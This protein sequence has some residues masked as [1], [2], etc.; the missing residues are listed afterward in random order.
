MKNAV[1]ISYLDECFRL[2]PESGILT[3]KCRPRHHF[4]DNRSHATTN[5]MRAGKPAEKM[6]ST[7]YLSVAITMDGAV[8]RLQIHR[9]IWAMHTGAW[10][11]AEIDH[12]NGDK[13]DN[14]ICNLREASRSQNVANQGPL[15][16]NKVGLKGVCPHGERYRAQIKTQG[17][18]LYLGMFDTPESAHEAY[19]TAAR[20]YH[21]EFAGGLCDA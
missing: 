12:I 17:E 10:P 7:G 19:C 21:G 13:A 11:A 9:I 16:R 20:K 6:L 4:Q 15:P 2:D 18:V 8:T 1:P 3:W 5:A 14:R